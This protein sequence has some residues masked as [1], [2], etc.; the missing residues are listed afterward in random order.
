M[1]KV[2]SKILKKVILWIT[3]HVDDDEIYPKQPYD[4][5]HQ[6]MSIPEWDV[7]F[8]KV[9]KITLFQL[10]K[11]ADY[12]QIQGLVDVTCKTVAQMF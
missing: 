12:L 6:Y 1:L 11:A 5:D 9:D 7:K 3:H 8:L 4:D 10:M 2:T